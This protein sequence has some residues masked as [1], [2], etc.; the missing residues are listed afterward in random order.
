MAS[1]TLASATAR[2]TPARR[3][4]ALA[5]RLW[6]HPSAR[7]GGLLL[8]VV[9]GG[10]L[11]APV[12]TPYDPVR[13]APDLRLTPPTLV[14]P[15]GNDLYGR[16]TL[17]R[18]LYGGR[19]SLAV[20]GLSVGLALTVGGAMGALVGYWGGWFDTV[21]MRISDVLLAFPAILLAIG[22]LAFLGGGFWNVV[23]AIG[24]IFTAPMARVARAAVLAVRHEEYVDAAE[25]VGAGDLRILR[26]H[27]LPNAAAPLV[28]ESTLRLALA[29]LAEAALSFLGLGTQPPTPTW[30]QMIAEG[31][32]VMTFTPW[33]AIGPG[34]A[35]TIT[36]LGFNLVGDGIRDAVDPHAHRA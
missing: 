9:L 29:I 36:V 28:V 13:I 33:P 20:G 3:R 14:H 12:L 27:I 2:W 11:F 6:R 21:V 17:T 16:D 4:P 34:L 1:S 5:A 7:T 30:G 32:T 19:I 22:L 35:I 18:V 15:L 8:V 26:R 23:L 31:R 25:A 10:A 24:I